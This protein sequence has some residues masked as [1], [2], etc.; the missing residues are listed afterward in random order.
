V[1]GA[2][3]A[4]RTAAMTRGVS[5]PGDVLLC[6]GGALNTCLRRELASALVRTVVVPPEPQTLA[7]L[8]CA[9]LAVPLS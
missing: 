2:S 1:S 8:G 6:G 3:I 7:A 5:Q 9:L 4:D